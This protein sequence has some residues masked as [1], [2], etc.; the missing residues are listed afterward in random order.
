MDAPSLT[1]LQVLHEP[2]APV[3]TLLLDRPAKLN[4]LSRVLLAELVEACRWL[5]AVAEL[6]VVVVRGAGRC[7]SAGFDLGDFAD[8]PPGVSTRDTADLGRLAAEAL[9]DVRPLTIAAVH[10]HCVGGG[11]V[12]AAACD[13]RVA[14]ESTRFAI[15]EVDLGIPLA[16]GGIPR[17]VRELG[18]A[19]TKELVLTCRPFD[20]AEARALRFVNRVVADDELVGAAD[21]LAAELAAKPGFALRTTKQQVNAV[22]EELAGTR[23]NANDADTLAAAVA[24]PESRA[25]TRRYLEQRTR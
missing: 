20:A 21:A 3:A 17:L 19:I 6:K 12:L 14:A 15:P 7:F 8:P 1:T 18:P 22:T 11:V 9:S 16:W 10:G 4:A 2:R 25:A 13:L 5:D 24:D 23:R